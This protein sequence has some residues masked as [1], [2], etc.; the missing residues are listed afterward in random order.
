MSHQSQLLSHRIKLIEKNATPQNMEIIY[1][2]LSSLSEKESKL[3]TNITEICK[4]ISLIGT[5][6][7]KG[8]STNTTES[9][10]IFDT[11]CTK[12]FM[13]LLVKYSSFNKYQINL[14]IIKT[15]SF[16]MINIKNTKYL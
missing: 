12:D 14:E 1:T 15:F 16:L 7:V 6:L 8:E 2:E 3:E 11:F 5:Y 9:E 4:L 13:K 10:L